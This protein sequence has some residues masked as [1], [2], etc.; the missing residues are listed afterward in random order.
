MK[1]MIFFK[2]IVFRNKAD[3]I[4]AVLLLILYIT[5]IISLK[6]ELFFP[7]EKAFENSFSPIFAYSRQ[8]KNGKT[9][10]IIQNH[11]KT[12]QRTRVVFLGW[13]AKY[14]QGMRQ[15]KLGSSLARIQSTQHA[16]TP[17]SQ[18]V[19]K[20]IHQWVKYNMICPW[21]MKANAEQLL[22]WEEGL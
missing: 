2:K 6:I 13:I 15:C 8:C 19:N 7:K 4:S 22:K 20:D 18:S 21:R 16:Y 9:R 17:Q 12:P 3:R 5:N 1:I 14:V 11:E 10:L